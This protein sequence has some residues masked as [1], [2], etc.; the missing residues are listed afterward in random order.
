MTSPPQD[1][2]DYF[3]FGKNLI[4]DDPPLDRNWEKFEMQTFLIKVILQNNCKIIE[5]GKNVKNSKQST[6]EMQTI[7][8]L[9]LTPSPP[10]WTFSTICDISCLDGSPKLKS[11]NFQLARW[12]HGVALFPVKDPPTRQLSFGRLV[13]QYILIRYTLHFA[14]RHVGQSL[15]SSVALTAQ[16]VRKLYQYLFW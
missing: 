10:L 3:E 14:C 7:L 13:Y 5:I 15:I 2:V 9:A 8:I 6:F 4:F 11:G 12:S 1:N 16:L